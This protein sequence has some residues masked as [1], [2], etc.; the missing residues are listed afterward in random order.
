LHTDKYPLADRNV[1]NAYHTVPTAALQILILPIRSRPPSS[2]EPRRS[3]YRYDAAQV[4]HIREPSPSSPSPR[5]GILRMHA[6]G[7]YR[8]PHTVYRTSINRSPRSPNLIFPFRK[9]PTSKPKSSKHAPHVVASSGDEMCVHTFSI[10]D[11][12]A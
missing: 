11:A 5:T 8:I 10:S 2:N 7:C 9:V 1:Q 4:T 6:V 3:T 12:V